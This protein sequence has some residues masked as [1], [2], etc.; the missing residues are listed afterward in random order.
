MHIEATN[1]AHGVDV[2]VDGVRLTFRGDDL[3]A[4]PEAAALVGVLPA[5]AR[6][7][8]LHVVGDLDPVFVANVG[9]ATDLVLQWFPETFHSLNLV[10]STAPSSH[11]RGRR[12]A[13]FFTGGVDSFHAL[14]K[15]EAEIDALIYV[16]GYDISPH[17]IHM[18]PLVAD[19]LRLVA[20]HYGKEFVEVWTDL[21]I[22]S[23]ERVWWSHYHGVALAAV[24]HMLRHRFQRVFIAASDERG[25]LIPWGT[26]PELDP[27][28]GGSQLDIVHFGIDDSRAEKVELIAHHDIV[29]RTLHVCPRYASR[30]YNCGRCEKCVRTMTAFA[31][32][33]AL[34]SCTTF[35]RRLHPWMLPFSRL[36]RESGAPIWTDRNLKLARKH[37]NRKMVR[38]ITWQIRLS[39]PHEALVVTTSPMR[40][41]LRKVFREPRV[42]PVSPVRKPDR[43]L[44]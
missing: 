34:D 33:G 4:T 23:N 32:V 6:D 43:D 18:H 12:T 35:S 2:D 14:I 1:S 8:Q 25:R 28:W 37:A 19:K 31:V 20:D 17:A 10:A 30:A 11:P 41:L 38:A 40:R 27:K 3:Q 21:R 36:P 22:W 29:H 7:A 26:H 15:N 9:K 24:A 13:M 16:H 39:R 42:T 44:A 5:M